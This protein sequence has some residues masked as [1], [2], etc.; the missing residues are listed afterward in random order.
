LADVSNVKTLEWVDLAD[1]GALEV[2]EGIFGV[3]VELCVWQL[4][5][6]G[7][8]AAWLLDDGRV[9]AHAELEEA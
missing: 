6:G 7:V 9:L 2:N 1:G 4:A 3:G 5:S 8:R